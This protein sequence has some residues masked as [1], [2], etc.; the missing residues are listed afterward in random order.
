MQKN[1]YNNKFGIL[2][3]ETKFYK[4]GYATAIYDIY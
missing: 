4:S 2:K 1:N 3:I